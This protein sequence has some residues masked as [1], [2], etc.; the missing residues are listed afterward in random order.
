[1]YYT[2]LEHF[3]ESQLLQQIVDL[4]NLEK[5][6]LSD[7]K[8]KSRRR[9]LRNQKD[10]IRI[11]INDIKIRN[12]SMILD[13]DNN[14][15]DDDINN[16]NNNNNHSSNNNNDNN[17]NNNNNDNNSSD[18]NNNNNGVKMKNMF[19]NIA[20]PENVTIQ[21]S[22][23]NLNSIII[24]NNFMTTDYVI[25][26]EENENENGKEREKENG[27][28]NEVEN[29]EVDIQNNLVRCL[30]QNSLHQGENF[31]FQ[32]S[33]QHEINEI[34]I[35]Q[36]IENKE[37]IEIEVKI[38]APVVK[39]NSHEKEI[40]KK[41]RNMENEKEKDRTLD[42]KFPNLITPIPY[43]NIPINPKTR[44]GWGFWKS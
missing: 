34:V 19:V 8:A 18:N 39:L 24:E 2:V 5:D 37:E 30:D 26:F 17:N 11:Y 43:N 22:D 7:T 40:E 15:N 12:N 27:K 4:S 41:C 16:N 21:G 3:T 33:L 23:I 32:P 1:M 29:K 14:N 10:R 44:L 25:K 31:L 35:K 9:T 42:P 13:N 20:D 28:E 36:E 6:L 38:E